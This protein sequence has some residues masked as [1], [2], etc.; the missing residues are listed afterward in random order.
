L[1]SRVLALDGEAYREAFRTSAMFH[2]FHGVR[3]V[4]IR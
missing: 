1:A 3:V 4:E 2:G